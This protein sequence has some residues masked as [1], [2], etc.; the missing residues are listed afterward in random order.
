MAR[1]KTEKPEPKKK[2]IFTTNKIKGNIKK[3]VAPFKVTTTKGIDVSPKPKLDA[4]G[5]PIKPQPS[6]IF[7]S[8]QNVEKILKKYAAKVR[9]EQADAAKRQKVH[10]KMVAETMAKTE[11]EK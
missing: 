11:G 6:R 4:A 10:D 8:S 9:R 2:E 5:K 1:K 7:V 3:E